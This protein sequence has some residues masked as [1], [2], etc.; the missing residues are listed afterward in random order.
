MDLPANG[1]KEITQK[2]FVLYPALWSPETPH[3][4]NALFLVSE[5]SEVLD[6]TTESFCFRT[7]TISAELGLF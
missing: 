6:I 4:Y 2:I 7:F 5:S 3:L 1:I